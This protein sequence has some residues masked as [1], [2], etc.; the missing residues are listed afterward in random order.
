MC[1]SCEAA[2]M[3]VERRHPIN[4]NFSNYMG[5][6]SVMIKAL[7]SCKTCGGKYTLRGRLISGMGFGGWMFKVLSIKV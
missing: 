5:G 3:V 2:V 7:V 6:N 1:S 4:N